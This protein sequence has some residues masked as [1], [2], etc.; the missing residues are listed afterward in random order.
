MAF[1]TG[2]FEH[3]GLE[4]WVDSFCHSF[5]GRGFETVLK[6][7][8]MRFD[9]MKVIRGCWGGRCQGMGWVFKS[10]D[11]GIDTFHF[12]K[13]ILLEKGELFLQISS[14]LYQALIDIFE[15]LQF[16]QRKFGKAIVSSFRS[17]E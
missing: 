13:V 11:P 17:N 10:C 1:G 3:E 2:K 6:G 14:S 7:F 9:V 5:F 8:Q 16:A 12:F 4:G 15:M